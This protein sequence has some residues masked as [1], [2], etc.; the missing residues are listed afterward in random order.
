MATPR[1]AD[2]DHTLR[3][4]QAHLFQDRPHPF[5]TEVKTSSEGP[6]PNVAKKVT[7]LPNA[8]M[9]QKMKKGLLSEGQGDEGQEGHE[10]K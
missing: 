5:H 3:G 6:V 7:R 4:D 9:Q 1:A 2:Q 10:P 8:G